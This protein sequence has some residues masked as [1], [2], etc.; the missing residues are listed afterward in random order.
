VFHTFLTIP[1]LFSVKNSLEFIN[2]VKDIKLQEGEL[3][4]LF[5]VSSLLSFQVGHCYI[6]RICTSRDND[7]IKLPSS[8]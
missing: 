2:K 3:L 7:N 8:K 5:E 1:K 4:L 6:C